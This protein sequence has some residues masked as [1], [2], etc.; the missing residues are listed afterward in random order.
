MQRKEPQQKGTEWKEAI[1][2]FHQN[3][4]SYKKLSV[5]ISPDGKVILSITE[6]KPKGEQTRIS[7]QLS[8]QELIFLSEK[9]K[10]IFYKLGK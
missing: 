4:E 6:G 5:N 10:L 3:G 9:L 1:A 8:E 7:F 2:L